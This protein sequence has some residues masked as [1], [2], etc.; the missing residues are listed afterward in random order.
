MLQPQQIEDVSARYAK[1]IA[2]LRDFLM[3]AGVAVETAG[4]LG[5]IASRLRQERSFRR[6]LTSHVWVLIDEG[7]RKISVADLL[8][9]VAIAAAGA[10][11]AAV[12][13]ER[14]AHD[15]LRFLMEAR[16]SLDAA[17][18]RGDAS[19]VS[20]VAPADISV[21]SVEP[22]QATRESGQEIFSAP[23][24][25]S[26]AEIHSV[27]MPPNRRGK[28]RS[29]MWVAA[30]CILATLS[31]GVW[32]THRS[33]S[34]VS[35]APASAPPTSV[36][37]PQPAPL[38]EKGDASPA[39]RGSELAPQ[40]V[41]PS[42]HQR[43]SQQTSAPSIPTPPTDVPQ[44]PT[45][46]T[47]RVTTPAQPMGTVPTPA[48][49]TNS[50]VAPPSSPGSAGNARPT[51]AGI[52]SA[53]LSRNLGSR[54]IPTASSQGYDSAANN[55]PRLLRR[56]PLTPPSSLAENDATL[57]ADVRPASGSFASANGGGANA[58]RVGIVRPTSLG[59]MAAYI[60]YS[61]VPT[62][63][64][65]AS[66]AHVQGEVTVRA[67]VDRDGNVASARVISGPPLLRDAALDAVQHWRYRPYISS[68]KAAPMTA[69]AVVDF[70]L[71]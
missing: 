31:I 57:V 37:I 34:D 61:P 70:Q 19:I 11:F 46:P 45:S 68:G 62:Y 40:T 23:V 5:S 60:Q 30:A 13:D 64:A 14:D 28:R 8:G 33:S 27:E 58:N 47:A 66:A 67:D 7:S 36:A 15:L 54:S 6:D 48:W 41:V 29:V 43:S 50:T 44:G 32:V 17:S 21:K 3:K 25:L 53:A 56:H 16:H 59:I 18:E 10:Q 38:A 71:P 20:T 52:P 55:R 24:P 63:P 22:F 4:T 26:P 2:E 35:S 39:P 69:T 42:P 12:A 1:E 49:T 65:A 51:L 9:V